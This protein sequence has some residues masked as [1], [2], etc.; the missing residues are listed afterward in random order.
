M[1]PYDL[2]LFFGL[3]IDLPFDTALNDLDPGM[4]AL[5][6]REGGNCLQEIQICGRRYLGKFTEDI[7]DLPHLELLQTNIHSFI[8]KLMPDLPHSLSQRPLTLL[9]VP[10]K[11]TLLP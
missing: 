10:T 2:R 1:S 3:Q 11:D 6:I 5:F 7:P 4:R 8:H 9:A